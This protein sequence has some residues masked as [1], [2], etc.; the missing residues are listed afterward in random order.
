MKIIPKN[1]NPKSAFRISRRTRHTPHASQVTRHTSHV[2][3][4]TR[5]TSHVTQARQSLG[6]AGATVGASETV[7]P[8][9]I[10]VEM[11]ELLGRI[12]TLQDSGAAEA[13]AL[14][15]AVLRGACESV[16][17]AF[18]ARYQAFPNMEEWIHN[19]KSIPLYYLFLF[20]SLSI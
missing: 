17:A 2:T 9:P 5:H 13:A 4:V 15:R 12:Q 19:R 20:S 1:I 7:Y 3:H 16:F 11:G 10:T 8:S 6:A 14:C 18:K